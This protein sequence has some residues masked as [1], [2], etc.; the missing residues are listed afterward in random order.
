[1]GINAKANAG[2]TKSLCTA[3]NLRVI[4]GFHSEQ[5]QKSEVDRSRNVRIIC[6]VIITSKYDREMTMRCDSN[7]YA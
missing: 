2:I 6:K 1:M 5:V 7:A 4:R 3:E